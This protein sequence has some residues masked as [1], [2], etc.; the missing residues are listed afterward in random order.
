M[1]QALG[2]AEAAAVHNEREAQRVGVM[3]LKTRLAIANTL[4]DFKQQRRLCADRAL[5][6][7]R[8]LDRRQDA[9]KPPALIAQAS[10]NT[11]HW[12]RQSEIWDKAIRILRHRHIPARPEV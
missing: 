8:E 10:S 7:R 6:W 2:H 12:E 9:E 3:W 5:E 4:R 11:Q 1:R